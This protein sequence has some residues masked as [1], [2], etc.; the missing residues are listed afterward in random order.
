[1]WCFLLALGRGA[2][3]H[4]SRPAECRR[5]SWPGWLVTYRDALPVRGRSPMPVLTKLVY[6]NFVDAPNAATAIRQT[7]TQW[8][9]CLL[10][11]LIVKPP[12]VLLSNMSL[13]S[14]EASG[15]VKLYELAHATH[16]YSTINFTDEFRNV[17]VTE[18][19]VAGW[20]WWAW[21]THA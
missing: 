13:K 9:I 20:A 3:P 5:L 6:S 21:S 10:T 2:S 7:V 1:M 14:N 18:V 4:F 11:Y 15:R 12:H 16:I 19:G 8:P 17:S